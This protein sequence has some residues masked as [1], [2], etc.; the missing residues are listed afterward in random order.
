M[1]LKNQSGFTLIELMIVVV[2]IGILA[3][4]ALPQYGKAVVKGQERDAV[5]QLTTI[6][7]ANLIYFAAAARYLPGTNLDMAEINTGLGINII[8]ADTTYA[9]T[10][11]TV[12]TYTVIADGPG[13]SFEATLTQAPV[14]ATN[15]CCSDGTCY[16]LPAC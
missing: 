2:L 10:R 16:I 14:S 3:G 12:N 13:S 4:F 1:K 9:Y 5:V 15:P 6:H 11:N 8:G 7:A